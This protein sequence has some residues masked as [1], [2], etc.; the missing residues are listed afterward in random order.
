MKAPFSLEHVLF[1]LYKIKDALTL[2]YPQEATQRLEECLV[3]VT[4]EL[5]W[6]Y[7]SDT[8]LQCIAHYLEILRKSI[9]MVPTNWAPLLIN[10]DN[11]LQTVTHLNAS[12]DPEEAPGKYTVFEL[13]NRRKKFG[14]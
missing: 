1:Q 6:T 10:L 14:N 12:R 8:E 2:G 7:G 3:E 9:L 13:E 5:D 11:L 4:N